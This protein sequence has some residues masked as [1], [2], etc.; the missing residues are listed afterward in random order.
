MAKGHLCPLC[1]TYTVQ[2]ETTNYLRCS[3]CNTKFPRDQIVG[4]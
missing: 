1:G 2:A 3:K 4:S